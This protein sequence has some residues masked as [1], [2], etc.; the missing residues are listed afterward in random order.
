VAWLTA[1]F[2]ERDVIVA[3]DG[4]AA[5]WKGRALRGRVSVD[6]RMDLWRLVAHA[7]LCIDLAPGDQIARECI[8]AMR[9]GIPIVVPESSGPGA[10]HATTA[11][12]GTFADPKGLLDAVGV[13]QDPASRAGAS[14]RARQYADANFGSPGE[15]VDSL[16]AVL[17]ARAPTG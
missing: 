2:A 8:E 13:L 5:A 12:G 6:S 9:F 4:V 3:E 10:T 11:Q 1:A 15:F 7:D 16:R 17:S 14:S